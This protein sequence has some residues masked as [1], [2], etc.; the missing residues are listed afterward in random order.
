MQ[1][2]LPVVLE[3]MFRLSQF[4][5]DLPLV[6]FNEIPF[7]ILLTGKSTCWS[8]HLTSFAVFRVPDV[9]E[10][11]ALV[12]THRRFN[13]DVLGNWP[14]YHFLHSQVSPVRIGKDFCPAAGHSKIRVVNVE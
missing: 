13:D 14:L 3:V 4:I 9:I 2:T 7:P 12:G 11:G 10:T 5:L 1:F 6:L 8:G